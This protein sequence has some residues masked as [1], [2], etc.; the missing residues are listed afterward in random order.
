MMSSVAKIT[1]NHEVYETVN[2][3][4]NCPNDIPISHVR[5]LVKKVGKLPRVLRHG[6]KGTPEFQLKEFSCDSL[7]CSRAL[8]YRGLTQL[9]RR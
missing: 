7:G 1:S 4:W 2:D 8:I 9:V 6:F 3:R 5:H